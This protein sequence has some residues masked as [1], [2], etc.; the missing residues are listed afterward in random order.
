[1]N[2]PERL[3]GVDRVWLLMERP[4]NPM[5]IL[6][7]IILEGRLD[8]T[9]LRDLVTE[10]FL[11]FDRFRCIP[12][13]N[14]NSADWI[15]SERFD[16]DDHVLRVALPGRAGQ[17]ELEALAGELA[18]TQMNP[19]RPL[20]AFHLVEHYRGGSAII[21]RIHHCYADGIALVQVLLSLGDG[22][23]GIPAPPLSDAVDVA[24]GDLPW[25]LERVVREGADL[26][27]KGLHYAL[28]PVQSQ[29]A[30]Q[31]AIKMAGELARIATLSDDAPTRLKQPLTGFRRVAWAAPI[32]LAEVKT[33]AKLLGCTVNDVLVSSLAGAL[34]RYLKSQGDD[35]AGLKI[36]ATVPVSLRSDPGEQLTLGNRFGLLFL[37]L[38]IGI[39]HPLERLYAVHATMQTLKHSPQALVVL[40]LL[41]AI[42]SLPAAVEEPLVALFSAKASLVASNLPGPTQQLRIGGVG[43]SQVLFWVPQSGSIGTGVSM[44]TYNGQ[45]QFGVIAD[46]QLVPKPAELVELIVTEFER[47]VFLV[48]LGAGS[49]ARSLSSCSMASTGLHAA[50]CSYRVLICAR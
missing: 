3:S 36:R 37:E 11:R 28:H 46:R 14:G 38:P 39:F 35:I 25:G 41:A 1:M 50:A 30:L 5:T 40:G 9:R 26:I 43:V 12:V 44:L 13:A 29:T 45:V 27:Q 48:L 21:V 19:A 16:V 15:A 20:W 7:L 17:H 22:E 6:G 23:P 47:L 10:R 2:A 4:T 42:G 33:I 49:L 34:G 8:R 24:T 32:S 31:D 18:S